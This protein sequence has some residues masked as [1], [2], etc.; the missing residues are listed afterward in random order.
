MLYALATLSWVFIK[1]YK[2]FFANEVANFTGDKKHPKSAY[3]WLFFYKFL[4]YGLFY[5]LPFILIDQA[6]YHTLA[7]LI[8]MHF[9][10]GWTLSII[11]SLAHVVEGLEFPQPDEEGNIQN[12]WAVHQLYTTANFSSS[13]PLAAFITGGLNQ[14]VEHHL[15]PNICSCHYPKLGEIVKETAKEFNHPYFEQSFGT[16]VKSHYNYLKKLGQA[17]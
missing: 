15:F 14:Q 13:S 9:V 10:A 3:F 7:G 4:H 5:A 6:W 1:D 17:A 12:T 2:K 11:F 16:A 8:M